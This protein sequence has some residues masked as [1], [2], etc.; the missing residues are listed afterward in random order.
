MKH[1][2]PV[3]WKLPF[4]A[5]E[6]EALASAEE[7]LSA[8]S[9]EDWRVLRAYLTE[10]KKP[11]GEPGYQPTSRIRFIQAASDVWGYASN[12]HAKRMRRLQAQQQ[13]PDFQQTEQTEEDRQAL[14]QFFN[15]I[16]TKKQ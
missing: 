6:R 10:Y 13:K 15:N 14:V 1:L 9:K 4:D 2:R 16:Q 12:W 8:L 11:Q 3:E 7:T 5:Q